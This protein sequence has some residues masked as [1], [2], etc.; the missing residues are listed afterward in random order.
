[1]G[2]S[3]PGSVK[4][5]LIRPTSSSTWRRS[6][7]Y[8]RTSPRLDADVLAQARARAHEVGAVAL[9]VEGDDVGAEQPLEQLLAPGQPGVDLRGRERHVQEEADRAG[10]RAAEQA[11]H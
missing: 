1:M 4:R 7:R 9:G 6:S 3:P 10:L 11:R 5:P 2:T 8:S